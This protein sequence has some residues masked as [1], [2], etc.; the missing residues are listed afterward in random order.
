M[1]QGQWCDDKTLNLKPMPKYPQISI[2]RRCLK[3]PLKYEALLSAGRY[4]L[5][6]THQGKWYSLSDKWCGK[7]ICFFLSAPSYPNYK[8]LLISWSF[9]KKHISTLPGIEYCS[10]PV[11]GEVCLRQF[12]RGDCQHDCQDRP[13]QENHCIRSPCCQERRVPQVRFL[14]KAGLILKKPASLFIPLYSSN[15][16]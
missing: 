11:H 13:S 12:L 16:K 6:F 1:C 15:L 14:T 9:N 2:N 10:S 8:H 7:R 5:I 4:P 3:A